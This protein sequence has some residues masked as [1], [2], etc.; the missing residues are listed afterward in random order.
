MLKT[1]LLKKLYT[2]TA[3]YLLASLMVVSAIWAMPGKAM[4]SPF[5]ITGVDNISTMNVP[6]SG[7]LI[8][9]RI[10]GDVAVSAGGSFADGYLLFKKAGAPV[11]GDELSIVSDTDPNAY[12]AVSLSGTTVYLGTG[13][14]KKQI[15]SID[16]VENGKN[17]KNL[18]IQ[19]AT[20][21]PNGGFEEGTEKWKFTNQFIALQGDS[22]QKGSGSTSIEVKKKA[23]YF[24]WN[25]VETVDGSASYMRLYLDCWIKDSY[26]ALHGPKIT[27]TEFEAN[28]GDSVSLYYYAKNTGDKYDVYGYVADS[29]TGA[30]QQ[31]FY[32]RG[33]ET[34][35]WQA[36]TR[37]I[38]LP[39]SKNLVFEFL[40]GSQDGTGG[41]LISSELLVDNVRV[42]SNSVNEQVMNKVAR[43]VALVK[44]RQ[45]P[46]TP[47]TEDRIYQIE[48]MDSD[49]HKSISA[50]NAVVKIHTYPLPPS[51]T[52]AA[53]PGTS[54][55]LDISWNASEAT[56]YDLYNGSDLILRNSAT[57][58]ATI[59]GL[60]PNTA[61]PIG[62]VA[63]NDMGSSDRINVSRYTNAAVPGITAAD[64]STGEVR[65]EFL[66]N[67]NPPGTRY[68]LER[69]TNG[70]DWTVAENYTLLSTAGEK[71]VCANTGLTP[72]TVYYY[73]VKAKNGDGIESAYSATVNRKTAPGAPN[74]ITV[75][76]KADTTDSLEI[77]WTEAPG[78]VN[79]DV[80]RDGVKINAGM[81]GSRVTHVGLKPNGPYEIYVK[82]KNEGG[83]SV[84]S[85]SITRYTLAEVPEL[86]PDSAATT[87]VTMTINN[88]ANTPGT[89]YRLERSID[90]TNWIPVEDFTLSAKD[91]A[92]QVYTNTGLNPGT[93]YY[94]RIQ[95]RNGDGI[96]TAYSS[97][98]SKVTLPVAPTGIMA[99]PVEGTH[100]VIRVSWTAPEGA[101]SYDIYRRDN[102]QGS[103]KCIRSWFEGTESEDQELLSNT[104][105]DYYIIAKNASG[106]S[107]KST[108]AGKYT[109]AAVPEISSQNS[110]DTN[111]LTINAQG[112]PEGTDYWI[113]YS[114]DGGSFWRNLGDWINFLTP[115]HAG[116]LPGVTYS[117][118]VK[119]RNSEGV[120]TAYSGTANARSN[121]APAIEINSPSSN[122]Y[123]SA[124]EGYGNFTLSGLVKDKDNDTVRISASIDGK[125]RTT[126]VNA[127]AAG[128]P[129]SLSWN[130]STDSIAQSDYNAIKVTGNDGFGGITQV[131]WSNILFVDKTG[132]QP[133][134]IAANTQWTNI[135]SAAV[136]IAHGA[137]IKA[138]SSKTEYMLSGATS[139]EW[140]AYREGGFII[141]NEGITVIRARSMDAVGNVGGI[142]TAQIKI[143]RTAPTE[144]GFVLKALTDSRDGFTGTRIVKLVSIAATDSGGA[145]NGADD[146]QA[147]KEM[148]I[149]NHA[150]FS[151]AVWEDYSKERYNWTLT[152]EPG[153]KTVFVRFRDAVGNISAPVTGSIIYDNVPPELKLSLPSRFSAK[154]GM[155]VSYDI[156][157]NE[158]SAL[159]GILS[160]DTGRI[161]LSASGTFSD[162][163]MA[164]LNAG[165]SVTELNP[166]KV[167]VN[168]NIPEHM[169]SE[170]TVGLIILAGAAC[171]TAGNLSV[172]TAGNASFVID[173]VAP[174]NQ[175]SLFI[176]DITIRGGHG[177]TLNSTS[178]AC[179]GMDSDSVRFAPAGYAGI[180]PANGTT[181]TST[182][183][184][185][186][187][188]NAPTAEGIYYLY[189]LDAA[190]NISPAS[191]HIL[192]VKND[193][194]KLTLSG[195]SAVS[196]KASNSVYYIAEY[197]GDTTAITLSSKEVALITSG[198]A[199]AY[200][201]I[202]DVEGQPLQRKIILENL[203]GEGTVQIRIGSG[204]AQ[205]AQGNPAE[206][207][208]AS[209]PV[210][211]DNTAAKIVSLAF[212][213][214][215]TENS[216]YAAKGNTLTLEFIADEPLAGVTGNIAGQAVA[217]T[218]ANDDST[219]WK[220]SCSIPGDSSYNALDG[221]QIPFGIITTDL[222]GNM[223]SETK[224]AGTLGRVIFDMTPPVIELT[225]STD[226]DGYYDDGVK[227]EFN[228]GIAV[229]KN[230]GTNEE[231]RM[232]SGSI[233]YDGGNYTVTVKDSA[234][235]TSAKG[236]TI[237]YGSIL[238]QQDMD[239]LE[240]GYA[241]GDSAACVTRD[242][243]LPAAAK[244][245]AQVS[246]Q[247]VSGSAVTVDGKVI[248][249]AYVSGKDDQTVE[250][251]AVITLE[252]KTGE[253][254]FRLTVKGLTDP[255]DILGNVKDDAR[256]ARIFYSYGD[257]INHVTKDITL[258]ALGSLNGSKLTWNS[259]RE[260]FISIAQEAADGKYTASVTRPV[261][262]AG[263]ISVTLTVTAEDAKDNNNVWSETFVLTVKSMEA[264][265]VDKAKE[266]FEQVYILYTE[267]DSAEHVTAGVTF[268]EAV[269]QGST[270]TWKSSNTAFIADDGRLV[271]RPKLEEGDKE[272]TVTA[273]ITNGAAVLSKT[274]KLKV[275]R[276]TSPAFD[277]REDADLLAI[278][279]YTGDSA[280]Q[281]TTHVILPTEGSRGSTISWASDNTTNIDIDG[282]VM[283]NAS[284]NKKVKLTAT[285]SKAGQSV[286]K[287]FELTVIKTDEDDILRQIL[288][289][290]QALQIVYANGDNSDFVTQNL[291][292]RQ[293]GANGCDISWSSSTGNVVAADGSVK[294]TDEDMTVVLKAK[295]KKFS[296]EINY[297]VSREKQ[298]TVKV[299][300]K[301]H[302]D[303]NSDLDDISIV[304]T[305]GDT[306]NSVTA[307]LYL[308]AKGKSGSAITWISSNDQYIEGD[309]SVTR[310][311]PEDKDCPVTLTAIIK[312][313]VTG[314][315]RTKVFEVTV[316][317]LTDK[318]AVKEAAKKLTPDEAFNFGTGD[319]WESIT[320]DFWM[321]T[322]GAYK[323]RI[324]WKSDKPSII[325]ITEELDPNTGKQKAT[326]SRQTQ[327]ENVI[328]TATLTL[329][330]ISVTKKYLLVVKKA[331]A[332]KENNEIR[333]DSGRKLGITAGDSQN[334]VPVYRTIVNEGDGSTTKVD[335]L[336]LDI[337]HV[338]ALAMAVNPKESEDNR[339][340]N[341]DFELDDGDAADEQAVEI[342]A[343]VVTLLSQRNI[344]MTIASPVAEIRLTDKE[345]KSLEDTG[346]DLYF[347]IVPIRNEDRKKE[348]EN[349]A[350]RKIGPDLRLIGA[351]SMIETNYSGVNTYVVLPFGNA[352]ISNLSKVRVY[353]NH[354]DGSTEVKAG[355]IVYRAGNGAG[356]LEP[357]GVEILIDK[358]SEFQV[359]EDPATG[360]DP[361]SPT[362]PGTKDPKTK[363]EEK[364]SGEKTVTGDKLPDVLE[365]DGGLVEDED[366]RA[367]VTKDVIDPVKLKKKFGDD[368]ELKD[369]YVHISVKK[370]KEPDNE[371]IKKKIR[372]QGY[373]P[374]GEPVKFGIFAEKGGKTVSLSPFGA[375][376]S[377]YIPIPEGE[378]ITT[379]VRVGED[380]KIIHIPTEIT[381]LDGKYY[382][383]VNSLIDGVFA[384]IWNP[385]EMRDME[386]HTAKTEVND[387]NSRLVVSGVGNN[388]YAP[389]KKMTRAEF[390]VL[391]IRGLGL[392]RDSTDTVFTDVDQ[393]SAYAGYI[394]TA[395]EYGIAK[396]YGNGKFG[397][398]DFITRE[399]AMTILGNAMRVVALK[400]EL[401]AAETKEILQKY[402]DS[403]A[404]SNYAGDSAARVIKTGIMTG[405][406]GQLAPKVTMTRAEGAACVRLLL[407]KAK[408]IN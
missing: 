350:K 389:D 321:L 385:R 357:Y 40:C 373:T 248:R 177:V 381:V 284:V 167:R 60:S 137:D 256:I 320:T 352:S 260:E 76:A 349:Q 254:T 378:K 7:E 24:N 334:S 161:K 251:K 1:G 311:G 33:D 356:T 131:D 219:S 329:N 110:A 86:V 342:P 6:R 51:L 387:L 94:Y 282:T 54:G 165:I 224:P 244:S 395:Y 396:G 213:S 375:Y 330:N 104:K 259:D 229:I 173:A 235:N 69:S 369:V 179:G 16:G 215:N 238:L 340:M 358:F 406:K 128:I 180:A 156:D 93:V 106:D 154:K 178:E 367:K 169:N 170:G 205:D 36:V 123:R 324:S 240:I 322:T 10:D 101:E 65:L 400:A 198:T 79:Y 20:P 288:E 46:R 332:S 285:I 64:A 41:K 196:V 61:Y 97:V 121:E 162:E 305:E 82:S 326:V 175:N 92:A 249:P 47:S 309:G 383:K 348:L 359:I 232:I 268:V 222:A 129:W 286:Q 146:P 107:A 172:E 111:N 210:K 279:Y 50:G 100:D 346:T 398:D 365:G 382:A 43:K 379:A 5:S 49:G 372:Q 158:M 337:N 204:S 83:D 377:L 289:D 384:L 102:G 394:K 366:V 151:G 163:D 148:Q 203:M 206:A 190:G 89:L 193:G 263:D 32:E 338:K 99:E 30:R 3:V 28:T 71:T 371:E 114:V 255:S 75:T 402:R 246:W 39:G 189:I 308:A 302:T 239:F 303:V 35:G 262:G 136:T 138:G 234:G 355:R 78:A 237:S 126:V 62:A 257:D 233:V 134:E 145:G 333:T 2:K 310:P 295:V 227:I 45:E 132:P 103:F 142:S 277:V 345:I 339:R 67:G 120:E 327:D 81:E 26:G 164:A 211:V 21:L 91:T 14:A 130:I 351:P 392:L 243:I 202:E 316:R 188:I 226:N 176:A 296:T 323:S 29:V 292:L 124:V 393:K 25:W 127:T 247:V 258:S 281:V 53:R 261:K 362:N 325:N 88:R 182:H 374:V 271:R 55:A 380:G 399:Q 241:P 191:S 331:G 57:T 150:D 77:V 125:T 405:S 230:T 253:K 96:E 360:T 181:I 304:Y 221:K 353:I 98:V 84:T 242:V 276:Q 361:T 212:S 313:P 214:D 147:P 306:A 368:T 293:K 328:I 153:T 152:E 403:G 299:A 18:K 15:G 56:G 207:S 118:R 37:K 274:F 52:V 155:T 391:L 199:N 364:P 354:S 185:S 19:F 216:E 9:V 72:N 287:V 23:P 11:E 174:D 59:S 201:K 376:V 44:V 278:G 317:K 341:I 160:G 68:C 223:S 220:A 90:G 315:T 38:T 4:A 58:S 133:P 336:I 307:A 168:I 192:T 159:S 344:S 291:K 200:V 301:D 95:A 63:G 283:R 108:T 171:D 109:F 407:Q 141:T 70:T 314:Q 236:F 386:K 116:I 194:P 250:L 290:T 266:D 209:N 42:L 197:S 245:G 264:T 34:N 217:F 143:D 87:S 319:I 31:L 390:T 294:S 149:S 267:G 297:W 135:T 408:L 166:A 404:I 27:S 269:I 66:N 112:N 228:E 401:P 218:A 119:A 370:L 280:E 270:V 48:A 397:P 252:G 300:K 183:G 157:I 13:G 298:F 195:P 8:P 231:R 347:R 73:R 388:L 17:G 122:V 343:S 115:Q 273:T 335:T 139:S 105:Y 363:D 22:Q 74:P 208:T 318:E 184:R 225:G 80:Y 85:R 275:L 144:G 186:N 117:Y 140:K 187:V 113:Q 12:G 265:E 312:N 272:V